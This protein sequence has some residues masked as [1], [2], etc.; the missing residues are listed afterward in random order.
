MVSTK[1]Q[2]SWL[3]GAS[4][5]WFVLVLVAGIY[6]ISM[7]VYNNQ[8]NDVG[9][10]RAKVGAYFNG[11]PPLYYSQ[12]WMEGVAVTGAILIVS[13]LLGK[14]QQWS[15]NANKTYS[16]EHLEE[17]NN[18]LLCGCIPIGVWA[19]VVIFRLT[20]GYFP[21]F[22]VNLGGALP[23]PNT[24]QQYLESFPLETLLMLFYIALWIAAI[25]IFTPTMEDKKKI[26]VLY[27]LSGIFLV[28]A[29]FIIPVIY[30]AFTGWPLARVVIFL[31]ILLLWVA[32]GL[33]FHF[34]YL[35]QWTKCESHEKYVYMEEQIDAFNRVS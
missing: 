27:I 31:L 24:W 14:L 25:S 12:Y 26:L 5:G 19:G 22:N 4:L 34:G 1:N 9:N 28:I 29:L 16:T 23:G 6:R 17:V 7:P 21:Y 35:K 20:T 18:T 3:A 8:G 15:S 32:A 33:F 30:L 13:I 10:L 2:E 11:G